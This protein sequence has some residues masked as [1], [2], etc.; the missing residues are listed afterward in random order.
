MQHRDGMQLALFS[1]LSN[2]IKTSSFELS[3]LPHAEVTLLLS[4]V[5]IKPL[6]LAM[7]QLLSTAAIEVPISSHLPMASPC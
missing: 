5:S 1:T 4:L 7:P 3:G 6:L 2:L